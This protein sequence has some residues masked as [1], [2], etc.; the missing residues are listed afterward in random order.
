MPPQFLTALPPPLS[1][2][3]GPP[4]R[5]TR[6]DGVAQP[7]TRPLELKLARLR[8]C[9]GLEEAAKRNAGEGLLSR[10]VEL[11]SE[12]RALGLQVASW[13]QEARQEVSLEGKEELK[14]A[15]LA[16]LLQSEMQARQEKLQI[17]RTTLQF[18]STSS[19]LEDEPQES[20]HAWRDECEQMVE[21][22]REWDESRAACEELAERLCLRISGLEEEVVQARLAKRS[23]ADSKVL[24]STELVQLR[25]EAKA[26]TMEAA[27][28]QDVSRESPEFWQ[29]NEAELYRL[30]RQERER[31][32]VMS[33]LTQ[34]RKDRDTLQRDYT[35][36]VQ[37]L[38]ERGEAQVASE[39]DISAQLARRREQGDEMVASMSETDRHLAELRHDAWETECFHREV[40]ERA[41]QME[42]E[43]HRLRVSLRRLPVGGDEPLATADEHVPVTWLQ[44]DHAR[45]R[46]EL[47]TA[48]VRDEEEARAVAD[49]CRDMELR[50]AAL[51]ASSAELNAEVAEFSPLL[52]NQ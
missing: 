47:Q 33:L 29:D 40:E 46:Q 16:R 5:A 19:V 27:A 49:A 43:R 22:N 8:R 42:L 41:Q 2:F 52:E 20:V 9:A 37:G 1:P 32:K 44:E 50:L 13:Q 21:E 11:R 31:K 39:Q 15:R 45:L 38:R 25:G 12:Q 28:M 10:A 18:A 6:N 24:G 34:A 23:D 14:G 35:R 4:A 51:E 36:V 3:V 7:R 26:L 30:R 17:A 48:V